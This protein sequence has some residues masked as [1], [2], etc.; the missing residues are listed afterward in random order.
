MRAYP[1]AVLWLFPLTY[2]AHLAEELWAGEG[3]PVWIARVRGTSMPLDTFLTLNGFGLALMIA[4]V[5]LSPRGPV[6][7]W[8]PIAMAGIVLMNGLLHALA[9]IGMGVYSPGVVTGVLLWI[10]LG[11]YT[12]ARARRVASPRTWRIGWMAAVGAHAVVSALAFLAP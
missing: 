7:A 12:L 1:A 9:T 2:I 10:P 3:F 11:G 8:I 5:V 4:G 6:F